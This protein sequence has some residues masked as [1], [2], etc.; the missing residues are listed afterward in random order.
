MAHNYEGILLK[1]GQVLKCR[2]NVHPSLL[3]TLE[4]LQMGSGESFFLNVLR[5]NNTT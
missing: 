5:Q 4:M 1:H 2:L 3:S